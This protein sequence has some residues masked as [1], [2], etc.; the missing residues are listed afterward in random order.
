MNGKSLFYFKSVCVSQKYKIIWVTE[1]KFLK[2]G[3][4]TEQLS[5]KYIKSYQ[6]LYNSKFWIITVFLMQKYL[7][8]N[9]RLLITAVFLSNMFTVCAWKHKTHSIMTY[10]WGSRNN[11]LICMD[12]K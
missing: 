6:D 8:L 1:K 11:D 3:S 4:W 5:V 7:F 10:F 12:S 2:F 9:S